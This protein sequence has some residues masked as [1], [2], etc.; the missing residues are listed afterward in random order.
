MA[1]SPTR[2]LVF[3]LRALT[4]A[5]AACVFVYSAQRLVRPLALTANSDTLYLAGLY[6][7]LV[8]DHVSVRAWSL[9]PAPSLF[10]DA[11]L[12]FPLRAVTGHP[13][14]AICAYGIGEAVIL[15]LLVVSLLR[16]VGAGNPWSRWTAALL[17]ISGLC[18]MSSFGDFFHTLFA[19]S[20]HGSSF[21][22]G[23][24]SASLIAHQVRRQKT[25]VPGAAG[26]LIITALTAG[27]D[28]IYL[29]WSAAPLAAA[30]AFCFFFGIANRKVACANFAAVLSGAW[31]ATYV[32]RLPAM[33]GMKVPT[34]AAEVE[35]SWAQVQRVL[36]HLPPPEHAPNVVA[37]TVCLLVVAVALT[38]AVCAISAKGLTPSR[39]AHRGGMT[40]LAAAALMSLVG[41]FFGVAFSSVYWDPA[42]A[43]YLEP[44]F[45]LP[46]I[47]ATV[48]LVIA[49]GW[50]L[51]ISTIAPLLVLVL[52]EGVGPQKS[53]TQLAP[54]GSL[55]YPPDVAC[56]VRVSARY[57]ARYG[58]GDYWSAR[59]TTELSKR[60]LRILPVLPSF[61]PDGWI[62]NAVWHDRMPEVIPA[63]VVL[64]SRLE[65]DEVRR[66]LGEP[67]AVEECAA[68][69]IWV[70]EGPPRTRPSR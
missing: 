17:G 50:M 52:P 70:Y 3:W 61:G 10:P 36:T 26:V 23:I 13:V 24:C 4:L 35:V 31:V 14:V 34:I 53:P 55:T 54:T 63:F 39:G 51:R 47:V 40:F 67:T 27:F 41:T 5:A 20:I 22:A 43:R 60:R 30:L 49:G 42:S 58:Y 68:E 64:L 18:Y 62:A 65:P 21:L 7:D 66:T 45:F 2:G 16:A 32:A 56:I 29:L 6:R 69:T 8:V 1:P 12:Y 19:P 33:F 44:L 9:Q 25:S 15:V 11:L 37:V 59:R 46:Y 38:F 57:G 48:S 28:R